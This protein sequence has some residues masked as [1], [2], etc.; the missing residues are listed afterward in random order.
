VRAAANVSGQ[1]ISTSLVR[2]S[3]AA[4]AAADRVRPA[5]PLRC[6]AP[7]S[8]TA[9][10]PSRESADPN[11]DD[12]HRRW[13][14]SRDTRRPTTPRTLRADPDVCCSWRWRSRP[15]TAYRTAVRADGRAS[16]R[17]AAVRSPENAP[18]GPTRETLLRR[19]VTPDRLST[20]YSEP[21]NTKL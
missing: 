21:P 15:S 1:S 14:R 2:T 10:H 8:G 3:L 18:E 11:P 6:G 19:I 4:H 17:D 16:R 7:R 9:S 20:P 13:T 5:N 12:Q